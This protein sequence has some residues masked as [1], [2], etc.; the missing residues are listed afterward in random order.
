MMMVNAQ[1]DAVYKRR[2]WT[3]D[4]VPTL[5]TLRRLEI[6]FPEVVKVVQGKR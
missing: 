3:A 6:D 1:Y 2:G 4:G 5:E